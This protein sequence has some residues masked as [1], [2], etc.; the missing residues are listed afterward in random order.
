M[1]AHSTQHSDVL[2]FSGPEYAEMCLDPGESY[3]ANVSLAEA[4]RLLERDESF[5]GDAVGAASLG[6]CTP[7]QYE[8]QL[9]YRPNPSTPTLIIANNSNA[10]FHFRFDLDDSQ[11][12]AC[13]PRAES[14]VVAHEICGEPAYFPRC[15]FVSLSVARGVV[16]KFVRERAMYQRLR[17]IDAAGFDYHDA[18]AWQM[19]DRVARP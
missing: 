16:R 7:D 4:L 3:R 5:W 11:R 2:V 17:W 15:A 6:W 12:I 10:G 9:I 8:N 1:A 14:S 18:N 19:I 13:D